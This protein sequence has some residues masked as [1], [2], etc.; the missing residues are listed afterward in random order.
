M[1]SVDRPKKITYRRT[2]NE[3]GDWGGQLE[4]SW[5]ISPAAQCSVA[6]LHHKRQ[7]ERQE[8]Q[9]LHC[10]AELARRRPG[11]Q[12]RI[13]HPNVRRGSQPVLEASKVGKAECAE[14]SMAGPVKVLTLLHHL[15]KARG[16]SQATGW[17]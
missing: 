10:T 7:Q 16:A 6:A 1:A 14:G 2:A 3:T 11:Q 12:Q 17:G 13:D 9:R 4:Q 8:P 5:R 15:L